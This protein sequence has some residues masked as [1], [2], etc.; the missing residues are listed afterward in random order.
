MEHLPEYGQ[1]LWYELHTDK[2]VKL[3]LSFGRIDGS[4][5]GNLIKAILDDPMKLATMR[6][7]SWWVYAYDDTDPYVNA[8]STIENMAAKLVMGL[9]H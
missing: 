5:L 2:C 8:G 4:R 6:E 3:K 1:L 7:V 9:H